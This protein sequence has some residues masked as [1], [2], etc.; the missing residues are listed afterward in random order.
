M[1]NQ[2]MK[3]KSKTDWARI[4]AMKDEEIDYSDIPPLDNKFFENAIVWK[5][6][7]KQLTIRIDSDVYDYF[8]SFG[9]KYQTRMN[10]ILRR[11]MEFTQNHPKTKSS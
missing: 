4:D 7:K 9:N 8:K 11:Y 1:K 10:A 6:R 3:K 5:P 2:N